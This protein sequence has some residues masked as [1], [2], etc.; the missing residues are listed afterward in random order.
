MR[1]FIVFAAILGLLVGSVTIAEAKKRKP[2]KRVQEVVEIAYQGGNAGVATPAATGGFCLVDPTQPFSCKIATPTTPGMKFLKIEVVD[3]S[4]QKAGGFISQ[5]DAD[6]DGLQDGYGQFCGGHA[7]P[8]ALEL[9]SAP[10]G[11]SL[12]AG[13]CSDGS[14][15]SIVTT[16]TIVATF[17]NLP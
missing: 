9:A 17:S 2:V 1:R 11:V 16:G 4:G 15:P 3:A 14:G 6:G 12:Y 10:V 8:V 13:I 7:E 5:Q